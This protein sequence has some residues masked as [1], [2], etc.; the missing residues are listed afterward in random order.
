MKDFMEEQE[1]AGFLKDIQIKLNKTSAFNSTVVSDETFEIAVGVFEHIYSTYK[2]LEKDDEADA[3][4][5]IAS[6]LGTY[7]MLFNELSKESVI[8]DT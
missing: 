2:R 6:C 4:A 3:G 8:L 1:V 7:I 5:Y